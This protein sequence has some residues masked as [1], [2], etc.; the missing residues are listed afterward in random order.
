[1]DTVV[2]LRTAWSGD[3]AGAETGAEGEIL[4]AAIAPIAAPDLTVLMAGG[5]LSTEYS[6]VDGL[7]AGWNDFLSAFE[8]GARVEFEELV[9]AGDWVVDMVRI[10]ARP[11]GAGATIREAAAAAFKFSDGLLTRVEFHLD[12]AAALRAAGVS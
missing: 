8:G 10:T 3:A 12:R 2:S 7:R 6:G 5:A 1:M 9:A 11:K 4:A